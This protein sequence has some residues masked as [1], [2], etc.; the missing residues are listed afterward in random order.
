MKRPTQLGEARGKAAPNP[1]H[2]RRFG[3]QR[4]CASGGCMFATRVLMER[5]TDE[6]ELAWRFPRAPTSTQTVWWR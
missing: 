4:L 1:S 5:V 2:R 3:Y 6:V